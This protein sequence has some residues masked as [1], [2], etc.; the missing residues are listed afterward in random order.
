[1]SLMSLFLHLSCALKVYVKHQGDHFSGNPKNLELFGIQMVSGKS[2]RIDQMSVKCQENLVPENLF[3]PN[4]TF[5]S[6][7]LFSRL[8]QAALIARV[9]MLQ[10]EEHNMVM[11]YW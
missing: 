11:V 10:V 6:T 5:E 1:M 9:K 2:Q 7:L 4:V 8:F 3:I